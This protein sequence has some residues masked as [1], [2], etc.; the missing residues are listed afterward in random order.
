MAF[1]P[2]NDYERK[3]Y[4][5]MLDLYKAGGSNQALGGAADASLGKSKTEFQQSQYAIA[6]RRMGASDS[7]ISLQEIGSSAPLLDEKRLGTFP[8][9]VQWLPP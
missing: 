1:Q 8:T 4:L 3:I 9:L 5:H 6:M 2:K 7:Q